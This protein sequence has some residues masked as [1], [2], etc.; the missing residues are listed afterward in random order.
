VLKLVC[1][2]RPPFR[3][4]SPKARQRFRRSRHSG[5]VPGRCRI[6]GVPQSTAVTTRRTRTSPSLDTSTSTTC[7]NSSRRRLDGH[8]TADPFSNGCPPAGLSAAKLEDGLGGGSCRA[9]PADRHRICF[10]RRRQFVLSLVTKVLCD[11]RRCARRQSECPRFHLQI[12]D[13]QVRQRIGQINRSLGGVG[14]EAIF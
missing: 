10:R 3:V 13:V 14:V 9:G 2:T 7:A 6:D 12:L 11:A 1:S 4:I 5:L 8:T